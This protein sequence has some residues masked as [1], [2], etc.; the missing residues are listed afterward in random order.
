MDLS[1]IFLLLWEKRVFSDITSFFIHFQTKK[2]PS[3]ARLEVNIKICILAQFIHNL[4]F[5]IENYL[6]VNW[7]TLKNK[8]PVSFF[9]I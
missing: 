6:W 4:F 7:A 3:G 5:K 1:N 2:L 8:G 9:R